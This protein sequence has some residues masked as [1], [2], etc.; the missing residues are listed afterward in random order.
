VHQRDA[1]EGIVAG[2]T[3]Q[4]SVIGTEARA[5]VFREGVTMI[6]YVSVVEIA[7]L[8]AIPEEHFARGRV[9]GA[10]G[11]QL[12]AIIWGTAVGLAIAHWFAFRLAAPAFRGERPSRID[13]YIGLAQVGGAMFVAAASSIPVLLFSDVRAQETTPDV[14]AVLIGVV[15]Y[16]VARATGRSRLAALF[17]SITALALGL[18]VALVKSLLAA[19]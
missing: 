12:L 14:P 5:E 6:L 11:G 10:V 19:H 9:T 1:A 2:L 16:L 8:A 3:S 4:E 17:Y 15:G 7:E 18:L 13:T